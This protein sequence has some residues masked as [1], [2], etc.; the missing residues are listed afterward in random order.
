M[1]QIWVMY[2]I[3]TLS[4]FDILVPKI[5]RSPNPKLLVARGTLEANNDKVKNE[6]FRTD[7]TLG[8][9]LRNVSTPNSNYQNL[10]Y[11]L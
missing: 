10:I 6:T 5:S 7:F 8:F 2:F 11:A 9:R 4:N 3:E 1:P